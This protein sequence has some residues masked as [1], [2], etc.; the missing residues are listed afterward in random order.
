MRW[1]VT[2]EVIAH[3]EECPSD[4]PLELLEVS[5][6]PCWLDKRSHLVIVSCWA[7]ACLSDPSMALGWLAGPQPAFYL[8]L[9]GT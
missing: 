5:L 9:L 3:L 1:L 2:E 8:D 7:L 6:R 4:R